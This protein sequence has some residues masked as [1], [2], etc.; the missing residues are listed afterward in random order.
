MVFP[1]LLFKFFFKNIVILD[2]HEPFALSIIS[3]LNKTEN[4]FIYLLLSAFETII[5]RMVDGLIVI[6][7]LEK[8]YF[9]N[10]GIDNLAVVGNSYDFQHH[11]S[12]SME[13]FNEVNRTMFGFKDEDIVLFYQGLMSKRRDLDTLMKLFK[14][15]PDPRYRLILLGD[16]P[17][18]EEIKETIREHHLNELI[19]IQKRVPRKEIM[20]YISIADVCL[21]LAKNTPIYRHY[22]PN[23][24][25]EY[26]AL[27]KPTIVPLL[28]NV[29]YLT[30]SKL[31]YYNPGSHTSLAHAINKVLTQN[32]HEL[33]E[34]IKYVLNLNRWEE[35]EVR[36]I[37][38][39]DKIRAKGC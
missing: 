36:L 14:N 37:E 5:G 3:Y 39:Y 17:M 29:V 16:G 33:S 34:S 11:D 21:V 7:D 22:T 12:I 8:K 4:S 30:N 23:K 10:R 28:D 27:E 15:L 25:F 32:P 31:P 35:D 13:N 18:I 38:F 24:L 19:K 26:L 20:K 6:N 9:K 2:R 1:A